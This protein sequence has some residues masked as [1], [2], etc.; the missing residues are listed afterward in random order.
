MPAAPSHMPMNSDAASA[1][2]AGHSRIR[3]GT[4]R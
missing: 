3:L 1:K 4:L 2:A